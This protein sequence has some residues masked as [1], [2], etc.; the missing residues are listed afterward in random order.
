MP[1]IYFPGAA[2]ADE[3]MTTF[4]VL[5]EGKD[6]MLALTSVTGAELRAVEF[7]MML[8]QHIARV[9]RGGRDIGGTGV[10]V[11]PPIIAH[12]ASTLLEPLSLHTAS[13]D[14]VPQEGNMASADCMTVWCADVCPCVAPVV[15]GYIFAQLHHSGIGAKLHVVSGGNNVAEERDALSTSALVAAKQDI[16]TDPLSCTFAAELDE[17]SAAFWSTVDPLQ[18]Q[19]PNDSAHR[20]TSV[21]NEPGAMA[22]LA[23]SLQDPGLSAAGDTQSCSTPR[24]GDAAPQPEFTPGGPTPSL[25][26]WCGWAVS[27]AMNVATQLF[28]GTGPIQEPAAPSGSFA[29][30]GVDWKLPSS[31]YDEG[32]LQQCIVVSTA[33]CSPSSEFILSIR[34]LS[35]CFRVLQA[36]G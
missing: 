6:Q 33:G 4:T 9:L 30:T 18:R 20:V 12:A 26:E 2:H 22:E 17:G 25:S 14:W 7:P 23:W 15:M 3:R 27:R 28:G 35:C 16:F 21:R 10:G 11:I 24:R 34:V 8:A 29:P 1:S 36:L 5:I 13:E 19:L 32:M 31:I